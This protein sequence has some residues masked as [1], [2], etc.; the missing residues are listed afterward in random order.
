MLR[1]YR[2]AE[3]VFAV[4][5]SRRTCS[6]WQIDPSGLVRACLILIC[7]RHCSRCLVWLGG[8]VTRCDRLLV[9]WII[10]VHHLGLRER[11]SPLVRD[12]VHHSSRVVTSLGSSASA[13][14]RW[15]ILKLVAQS[16]IRLS[17]T[18]CPA[19]TCSRIVSSNGT[20]TLHRET[21]FRPITHPYRSECNTS[22][23]HC[24]IIP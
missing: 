12:I 16:Q 3:Q 11:L 20:T 19:G 1:T 2:P 10:H 5:E 23:L 22:G 9:G 17:R 8:W 24:I 13:A 14:V 18:N 15:D 6:L 21:L 7:H 4:E